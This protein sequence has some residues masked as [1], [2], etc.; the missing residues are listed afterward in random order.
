MIEQKQLTQATAKILEIN[1]SHPI[2]HSLV[3]KL[4]DST[5]SA[6]IEDATWLLFDQAR[7]V[8]GEEITDPA[9]FR[10]VLEDAMG[11]PYGFVDVAAEKRA[12]RRSR[13]ASAAPN[14]R[15]PAQPST[16]LSAA[17]RSELGPTI[18]SRTGPSPTIQLCPA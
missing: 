16:G 10:A 3:S 17:G 18:S 13:P 8:E 15:V 1:P 2:I 14:G 12:T 11:D 7:I 6:H 4:T 5:A 9:A